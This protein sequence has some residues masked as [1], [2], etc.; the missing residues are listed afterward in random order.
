MFDLFLRFFKWFL[1][2]V[3][4]IAIFFYIGIPLLIMAAVVF[5]IYYLYRRYKAN[6]YTPEGRKKVN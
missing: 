1:I 5:G 3:V 2:A 4:A 6:R